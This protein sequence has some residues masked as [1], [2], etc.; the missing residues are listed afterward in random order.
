MKRNGFISITVIYSFFLVFLALMMFI[1][2]N[3][4]TSRNLLNNVK[5][6]I[7]NDISDTSFAR[8]LINNYEKEGLVINDDTLDN[9][10]LDNS[11]RF[12]G[13]N[14]SNYVT[15]NNEL[16]RVIGVIDGKVKIIKNNPISNMAYDSN[17]LNDYKNSSVYTYLNTIFLLELGEDNSD[18]IENSVWYV[19]GIDSTFKGEIGSNIAKREIGTEKNNGVTITNKIGLPYIA[20]YIYAGEKEGYGNT[21]SNLNNWFYTSNMWFITRM[22]DNLINSYYLKDGGTID[23]EDNVNSLKNIK[24]TFYLRGNVRYISGEGTI[25]D[26]YVVG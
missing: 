22:S 12:V 3:M 24:P 2:V 6:T 4:V 14:P 18:L 26:P 21:V 9:S 15:F 10:A 7:K 8:Y 17:N 19:G 16:Y 1:I 23:Y 25:S 11:Y 20:D 5:K 13:S